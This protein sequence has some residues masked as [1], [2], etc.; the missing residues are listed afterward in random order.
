MSWRTVRAYG[1]DLVIF[2]RWLEKTKEP[3]SGLTQ[4]GLLNFIE[5][6]QQATASPN[7]IN[8]QLGTCEQYY[9]FIYDQ[10]LPRGRGVTLPK[11]Y[12]KGRGYDRLG[13]R[14]R[15]ST[16]ELRLRVKAP[17]TLIE[18]L[19]V[20]E[21]TGFLRGFGHYR[22]IAIVLSMALSGLRS[23]EVVELRQNH[24]NL[25]KSE[26][27][28]RGKGNKERI[29]PVAP[30]LL[31][32]IKKYLQYER[33]S[34][35]PANN[36]FVNLQGKRLGEAMTSKGI[37]SL[38]SRHRQKLKLSRANPHRF[39]H[40]FGSDMARAGMQLPVLQKLMGHADEAMTLRYIFLNNSDVIAEYKKTME[41]LGQ[42]YGHQSQ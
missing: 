34:L 35:S 15:R 4:A 18:P 17:K 21:V 9:R 22:D 39:R 37:I 11:P 8:R 27:R 31:E 23:I 13:I 30:Q 2:L 28:I 6:Q 38:F 1:F 16:G 10:P 24:V 12:Y 5:S 20:E 33:P 14:W 25:S 41:R 40:T 36:L 7:T 3:L 32:A 26:M 42:R 19:T 29:L